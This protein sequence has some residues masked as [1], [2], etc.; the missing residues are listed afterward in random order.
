MAG[1]RLDPTTVTTRHIGEGRRVDSAPI[2]PDD[3]ERDL[4]YVMGASMLVSQRYVIEVG[5]MQDDYFLYYE[6]I[7]WALRGT[8]RFK[9]GYAPSSYV[10]HKSGASSSK[11][12]NAFSTRFY[13]RNRIRFARRFFPERLPAVRLS[14]SFEFLRQTLRGRWLNARIVAE[15]LRD[16][17]A[18]AGGTDLTD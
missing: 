1:A 6:E 4:A 15:T 2:H 14:L 17:R 12:M 13:Y 5:L 10:F 7:D 3:V 18:L 9:L 11:P 16:F 8:R